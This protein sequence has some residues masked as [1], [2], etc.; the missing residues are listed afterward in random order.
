MYCVFLP[1]NRV[2]ERWGYIQTQSEEYKN[3]KLKH[4]MKYMKNENGMYTAN[5]T[6]LIM[7]YKI[8]KNYFCP[9]LNNSVY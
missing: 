2:K 9:S 7:Y 6:A 8:N 3:A 5:V 1:A 4:F